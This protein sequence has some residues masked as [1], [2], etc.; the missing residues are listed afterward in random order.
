MKHEAPPPASSPAEE[1]REPLWIRLAR[2]VGAPLVAW[3][4]RAL[5]RTWR[6][7][8]RGND[9]FAEPGLPLLGAFLHSG[10]LVAAAVYRDS[11]VHVPVS[12]S[13]DGE[14]ITAVMVHLGFGKTPRGSSSRGGVQALKAVVRLVRDGRQ[15]AIPVDGPRGPA[16]EAKPG[17]V[18]ASR[19]TG[20]PI[21]P[22]AFVARPAIRF[23][24]WDRTVLPLPFARVLGDWLEPIPVARD[25]SPDAQEAAR[26]RVDRDIAAGTAAL[27]RELGID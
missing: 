11:G 15:V 3:L 23:G 22:V 8:I 4:L 19:L 12:Q 10:V 9:P 24:S 18:M 1:R 7:E 27:A 16:G 13:R 26:A 14:H 21:L 17:V 20:V 5:A 25:A 6:I 2:G